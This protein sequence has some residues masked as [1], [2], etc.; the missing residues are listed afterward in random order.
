MQCC[1]LQD[2][3]IPMFMQQKAETDWTEEEQKMAKEYERKV[4]ELNEEREKFRK[5]S[6]DYSI[7]F[8]SILG[9][10]FPLQEVAL[11]QTPPTFS[12]LCYPCPHRSLLPHIV[13]CPMT[14]DEQKMANEYESNMKE[15]NE[16][17]W[18]FR[19]V[20]TDILNKELFS[21]SFSS[22]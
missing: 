8:C 1:V 15:L 6:T 13:I 11:S 5:V 4:K 9:C 19:E 14:L 16:E 10:V 12:A 2:I 7:L 20:S 18:K 22:R 21:L 3:P 17:R